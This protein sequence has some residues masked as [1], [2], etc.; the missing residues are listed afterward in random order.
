M[1]GA[2]GPG[3]SSDGVGSTGSLGGATEKIKRSLPYTSRPQRQFVDLIF[4]FF[5]SYL[6]Y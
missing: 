3:E 2:W 1:F 4:F 6:P 5:L